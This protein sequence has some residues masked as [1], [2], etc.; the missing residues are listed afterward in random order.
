M[1]DA[2]VLG[3]WGTTRLRLFLMEGA[4]VVARAEGPGALNGDAAG[5]LAERLGDWP[6][7]GGA[8]QCG[9]AGAQGAL[10]EAP[11]A[12]CPADV[13]QWLA[14]VVCTEA[15]DVPV[16]V[17]P[18]LSCRA[19]GVPDV[20][21]GEETQVFGAMALEPALASGRHMLVLP[22]THSKWVT[23]KDGAILSFRTQPTGELFALLSERSTLTGPD[24]PGGGTFDE[25]FARG[26][27][28]SGEPLAAALFEARAARL[29]DGRSKDWSR[30]YLS[31][32]L[33]GGEVRTVEEPVTLVGDP[34]LCALYERALGSA[35]RIDGDA[36]VLAGLA[37]AKE[38]LA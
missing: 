38:N 22:G 24:M 11:Y 14:A 5:V 17:L 6:G 18:G 1:S 7:V 2:F 21:R 8:I 13:G 23:V 27:E 9:M 35:R 12:S 36:A 4:Q 10:V 16:T 26:L 30:G 3:D 37:L 34:A 28:R 31:G 19:D 25:G 29:L 33:I 15:A 20:M 32:L